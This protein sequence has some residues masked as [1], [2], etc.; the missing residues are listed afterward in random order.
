MLYRE[1]YN[2]LGLFYTWRCTGA[3]AHCVAN[4]SPKRREKI[5]FALARDIVRD[6]ISLGFKVL[7]FTGGESLLYEREVLALARMAS[8]EGGMSVLVMTNGFWARSERQADAF[9]R[10]L[11]DS[12]VS[13]VCIS[14]D[15][16]H[17]EAGLPFDSVWN[18]VRAA[19]AHGL[20]VKCQYARMK[21]DRE[22]EEFTQIAEAE[23]VRFDVAGT[24]P[25]GRGASFDRALL[26]SDDQVEDALC[27]VNP[28]ILPSLQVIQ[29]CDGSLLTERAPPSHP[30]VLGDLS[31]ESLE[32]I[33]LGARRG[34]DALLTAFNVWGPKKL[35]R[36]LGSDFWKCAEEPPFYS[37]CDLCCRLLCD[38][39]R[40]NELRQ[41]VADPRM[42]LKIQRHAQIMETLDSKRSD[43]DPEWEVD[44]PEDTVNSRR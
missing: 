38:P 31:E 32:E 30:V 14:T 40:V 11:A 29:C 23:K 6:A 42:K 19:R 8:R 4:S 20:K 21:A 44:V 7:S 27:P 9:A 24:Q 33:I 39:E 34:E 12:G 15:K 3:C 18:G 22:L 1:R 2:K 43:L 16:H 28:N 13:H 10:Q 26:P 37:T 5:D 17:V 36:L 25:F 35:G 41:I